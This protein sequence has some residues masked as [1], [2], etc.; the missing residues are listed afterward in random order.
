MGTQQG[1][2]APRRTLRAWP[3]QH[4]TAAPCPAGAS[5]S[6]P[7]VACRQEERRQRPARAALLLP[8]PLPGRPLPAQ[9]RPRLPPAACHACRL[10]FPAA[11]LCL[12]CLD[13]PT[14]QL[15]GQSTTR[16]R[17]C[18]LIAAGAARYTVSLRRTFLCMPRFCCLYRR[19]Q[20][21]PGLPA[22]AKGGGRPRGRTAAQ[23]SKRGKGRKAAAAAESEHTEMT[24]ASGGWASIRKFPDL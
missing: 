19:L 15:A 16:E 17:A 20:L 4:C 7:P 12:P 21:M 13:S 18:L 9:V 11:R 23:P 8:R 10:P 5:V 2:L 14:L 3:L 24:E 1:L 6:A 22:P